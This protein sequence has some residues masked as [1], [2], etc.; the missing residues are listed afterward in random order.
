M[1]C[2]HCGRDERD[3]CEGCFSDALSILTDLASG[4]VAI[5]NLR[6][7]AS[8]FI[9]VDSTFKKEYDEEHQT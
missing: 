5:S 1:P 4:D 7:R 6:E 3:Y 2:M 9:V 8:A